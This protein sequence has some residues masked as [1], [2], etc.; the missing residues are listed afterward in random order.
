M[1]RGPL[2]LFADV[3]GLAVEVDPGM[4]GPVGPK[5]QDLPWDRMLDVIVTSRGLSCAIENGRI[6][7]RKPP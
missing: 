2:G 1:R 4:A 5:V 3:S 7:I 6:H